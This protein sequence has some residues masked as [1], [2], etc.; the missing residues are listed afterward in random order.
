MTQIGSALSAKSAALRFYIEK[1]PLL[2]AAI[3]TRGAAGKYATPGSISKTVFRRVISN[4]FDKR[5]FTFINLK[6]VP[7]PRICSRSCSNTPSP[8]ASTTL[9]F[10]KSKTMSPASDANCTALRRV[11]VSPLIIWPSRER[12][13]TAFIFLA[14]T[15]NMMPPLLSRLLR[16]VS[17]PLELLPFYRRL[18][19]TFVNRFG[20]RFIPRCINNTAAR[21]FDRSF[22]RAR[23]NENHS[24]S[25]VWL[26]VIL[27]GF[28]S[29]AQEKGRKFIVTL[30]KSQCSAKGAEYE[31]QGQVPNNVRR[32]APGNR[33]EWR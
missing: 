29:V 24:V 7:L 23:G 31:S 11:S 21:H 22:L 16:C 9:T 10:D 18:S 15:F 1:P 12:I 14:C 17:A 19:S 32:V 2:Q 4:T 27:S 25:I 6:W 5:S 30:E 3:R 28:S 26:V 20:V 13:S 33:A 8:W